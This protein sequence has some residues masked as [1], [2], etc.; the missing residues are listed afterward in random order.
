MF[1]ANARR[2]SQLTG[3]SRPAPRHESGDMAPHG[4]TRSG[5]GGRRADGWWAHRYVGTIIVGLVILTNDLLAYFLIHHARWDAY[6]AAGQQAADE[7]RSL[8]KS[9]YNLALFTRLVVEEF[10]ASPP[11]STTIYNARDLASQPPPPASWLSTHFSWQTPWCRV[12]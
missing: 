2:F 6:D 4:E 5:A 7:G 11:P 9:I 3:S 10:T 12:T 8:A 1:M